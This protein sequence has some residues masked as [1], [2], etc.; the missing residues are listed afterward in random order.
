MALFHDAGYHGMYLMT[1]NQ[2]MEF[3]NVPSGK[4]R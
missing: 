1:E 2:L 3:W 4:A